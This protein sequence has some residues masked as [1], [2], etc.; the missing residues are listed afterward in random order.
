MRRLAL[1]VLLTLL[2]LS[3]VSGQESILPM[4]PDQIETIL[5]L[6]DAVDAAQIVILESPEL[7][8]KSDVEDL[9]E[10][11]AVAQTIGAEDM[12]ARARTLIVLATFGNAETPV[13]LP[14]VEGGLDLNADT[15]LARDTETFRRWV[16]VGATAGA[17]ALGMS[18][19]FHW[20]AE[21]NYQSWLTETDPELG[22]QLFRAW[23]GYD[24]LGM[25]LGT[26]TL[27]SVG[28]AMP[29]VFAITPPSTTLATPP[30]AETYTPA[31]RDAELDRLYAE[32]LAIVGKLNVL[33]TRQERRSLMT[34]ISLGSGAAGA[35]AAGTFSYLAGQTYDLYL[36]APNETDAETLGKRVAFFDAM[37]MIGAGI[38]GA[39]LGFGATVSLVTPNR[40]RLERELERVN[41]AIIRVRASRTID[42]PDSVSEPEPELSRREQRAAAR[43]EADTEKASAEAAGDGE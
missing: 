14:S 32:R 8:T 30:A 3:W 9:H 20:L 18:T 35:I 39:G 22:D 40:S 10:L 34:T 41:T 1:I 23:R 26:A 29:F 16:N 4:R 6:L 42:A 31:G 21:R 38:G 17:A 2:S 15:P 13:D 25:S 5:E 12:A 36:L 11:V 27:L 7:V 28:V 19:V 37:T 24:V 43:A 33:N